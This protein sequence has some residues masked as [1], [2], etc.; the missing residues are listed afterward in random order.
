MIVL[1]I[2]SN[3]CDKND[4]HDYMDVTVNYSSTQIRQHYTGWC[5]GYSTDTGLTQPLDIFTVHT[6]DQKGALLTLLKIPSFNSIRVNTPSMI[7]LIIFDTISMN[8]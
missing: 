8:I 6:W 3:K 4:K 5:P 1:D 2:H 7:Q